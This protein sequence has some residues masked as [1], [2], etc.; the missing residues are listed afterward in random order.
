MFSSVRAF[1]GLILSAAVNESVWLAGVLLFNE[2]L[3]EW[4]G[5]TSVSIGTRCCSVEKA[6]AIVRKRKKIIVEDGVATNKLVRH[7]TAT[8]ED[9]K[10][11]WRGRED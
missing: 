8:A 2:K 6:D 10:E 9:R 4:R 3:E 11:R 5:L 1:S 7:A